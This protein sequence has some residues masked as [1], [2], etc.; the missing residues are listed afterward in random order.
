MPAL[1][2]VL[3]TAACND[4]TP[5]RPVP[6]ENYIVGVP[7]GGRWLELLNSDAECYGGAGFGNV[8]AALT[9]RR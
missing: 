3:H 8:P 2:S 4:V 9:A 1:F 5:P 6:R 7:R